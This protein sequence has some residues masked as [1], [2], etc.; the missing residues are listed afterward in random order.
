[1]N[2]AD[3]LVIL[4]A[5]VLDKVAAAAVLSEIPAAKAAEFVARE[6]ERL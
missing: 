2:A 1:M 5:K 6:A 4:K 3:R